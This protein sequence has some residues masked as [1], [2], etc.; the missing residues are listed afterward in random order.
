MFYLMLSSL[1]D[2]VFSWPS[3]PSTRPRNM[4]RSTSWD[5]I[6]KEL[7]R[8]SQDNAMMNNEGGQMVWKV[9]DHG[10]VECEDIFGDEV[11]I[12]NAAR[13]S[14]GKR[15]V[16]CDAQDEKLIKYLLDHKHYSPFR[17]VMFRFH[18]KAPEFVMRQWYKHVVG[19]EWTSSIPSQ[20]HGWNEISGRYVDSMEYYEPTVWREQSKD[21]KQG[22]DG[23]VDDQVLCS[24]I[25][26][27]TID[28]SFDAYKELIQWGVAKEQAR[29]VLPLN[30]YTEVIWTPSLQALFHFIQ[31]RDE[32]HAQY[33]IREYAKV[34]ASL[35]RDKFPIVY[36]YMMKADKYE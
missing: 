6:D 14:F 26:Q 4:V 25:F 28:H 1:I 19:C 3:S 31:L 27:Q 24:T 20:L 8:M 9:L 21:K 33:E 7:Q 15:K 32:D 16:V 22:S 29:I 17:H 12:V 34:F 5:D 2:R 30:V 18:I 10:F 13:V 36:K 35:L 11:V 23:I